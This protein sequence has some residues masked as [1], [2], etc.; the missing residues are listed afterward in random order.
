MLSTA[1]GF[2]QKPGVKCTAG[3]RVDSA[4]NS[5]GIA[6]GATEEGGGWEMATWGYEESHPRQKGRSGHN[7]SGKY[8]RIEKEILILCE[9]PL[10][11]KQALGTDGGMSEPGRGRVEGAE[12][13]GSLFSTPAKSSFT[14]SFNPFGTH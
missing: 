7:P 11:P 6:G 8:G 13:R 3:S 14:V 2:I 12:P 9:I 5:F 1:H 10:K 4:L